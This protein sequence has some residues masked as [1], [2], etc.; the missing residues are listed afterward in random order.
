M[1]RSKEMTMAD[2]R[3]AVQLYLE[4]TAQNKKRFTQEEI[5]TLL[6]RTQGAIQKTIAQWK[7]DGRPD[8]AIW[9]PM[10]QVRKD[11]GGELFL[12]A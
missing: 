12:Y 10:R 2:K 6:C 9:I 7:K 5:G 3:R 11:T 1:P 8:P 4:R